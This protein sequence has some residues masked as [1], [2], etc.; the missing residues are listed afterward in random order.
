MTQPANLILF[1]SDNHN[2][3]ILGCYG[4]P[5]VQTP[6]MDRIAA[7][8]TRFSNAYCSSTL[9]CPSRASLAT[10]LYPHQT[11]F[12]DNCLVF[13]GRRASWAK[14]IRDQGHTAVSVGKLHFRS[15]EDDNGFSEE[16]APMHIINGVGGLVMLLRWSDEEPVQ[17]S[18]WNMYREESK[19]GTS[20]YQDYDREISR[21]AIEW[22]REHALKQDK[23]WVLYVSYVSAHPPFSVPERLWNMYPWQEM[24]LPNAYLPGERPEHPAYAHL[25]RTKAITP[26]TGEEEALKKMAAGYFG[27]VTHLDE[28]IGEVMA[29]A[30]ALGLADNTRFAYT[31][32]HGE[33]FGNHGL[34][35]KCQLLETAAAV[36]LVVSG[37]GIPAGQVVDQ[38]TSHVDLYPTIVE[39]AGASMIEDDADLTGASLWP[40]I[41]G[42][43]TDRI[44]FAEY[45]ASCSRRGSFMLRRGGDKLIYHAGMPTEL[46]DL[47]ADPHEMQ[48]RL[49]NAD[50]ADAARVA[51]ELEAEL[52]KICDPDAVDERARADQRAR[53]EELGGQE[54][55]KAMGALTRTPPP[56]ADIELA[57]T[58]IDR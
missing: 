29:A 40:A 44:G 46:Y 42:D 6:N 21:L 30:E 25:R 51:A 57:D 10:G 22:L 15:T 38:I 50:D 17:P 43:E 55:I 28:Q 49:L 32:D 9:C 58:V 19:V 12:W 18:Q 13:D 52:R 16:V 27:L 31:S 37:P 7:N 36:P 5:I 2:R 48:D 56:G 8:G 47:D 24:P 39:G 23:P 33:S 4:H 34:V 11:G 26:M 53:I 1:Q 20:D 54:H 45:H 14:R 3:D 35:G 41:Q